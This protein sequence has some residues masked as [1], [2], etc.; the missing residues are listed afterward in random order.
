MGGPGANV[1]LRDP[2][3]KQQVGEL[4]LWL[5]SIVQSL[6]GDA[7][8]V[9]KFWLKEDALFP[10]PVSDCLFYLGLDDPSELAEEDEC[11]QVI[12]HLG[13]W[14]QQEIGISSGCNQ[15]SDHKTLGLLILQLAEKYDGLINMCGAIIPPLKPV[16]LG[17]DFF[18]KQRPSF[19]SG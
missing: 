5:Q 2:L 17:K 11:R 16:S 12:E 18:A 7:T 19:S 6:E 1:L 9:Y 4:D 10:E 8:N 13:Y 14:P 15:K 3:T